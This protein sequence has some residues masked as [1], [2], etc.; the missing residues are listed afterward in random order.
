MSTVKQADAHLQL[1]ELSHR[2]EVDSIPTDPDEAA[3]MV[4]EMLKEK[5]N[6]KSEFLE[7]GDRTEID[8]AEALVQQYPDVR[9]VSHWN[10]YFLWDGK[11]WTKDTKL[12]VYD[13]IR[14]IC[15]QAA[16]GSNSD[17]AART[18]KK[19][20]TIAGIERI[21]RADPAYAKWRDRAHARR[22]ARPEH[23]RVLDIEFVLE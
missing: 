15:K 13:R 19:S 4:A 5:G 11:V 22:Y 23:E 14:C 2:G 10:R 9:Y 17:G 7:F 18:L 21:V 8:L 20:Q 3:R 16:M 1:L 6:G 12:S